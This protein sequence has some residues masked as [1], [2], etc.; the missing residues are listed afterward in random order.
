MI[1][2][3]SGIGADVS[4]LGRHC[5][6]RLARSEWSNLDTAHGTPLNSAIQPN[7]LIDDAGH[8]R[9]A[10]F[11]L[12]NFVDSTSASTS[13]GHSSAIAWLAPELLVPE[14]LGLDTYRPTMASDV[15]ALGSVCWEVC[16]LISNSDS[17]LMVVVHRYF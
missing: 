8:V 14:E 1:A 9:L 10:D 4:S 12:S 15:Y 2:F 17:I 5:A 16:S 11:G 3:R 13:F 6:W 7:I